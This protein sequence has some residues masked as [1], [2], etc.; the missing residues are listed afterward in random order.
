MAASELGEADAGLGTGGRDAD[1]GKYISGGERGLEQ[2]LEE[3]VGLDGAGA[4]R[5]GDGQFAI[6]RKHACRQFGGRISEGD[7]AA[8]RAAIADRGMTD[9]RHGQGDER[10]PPGELGRAFG[11]RVAHQRAD[12]QMSVA[13]HNPVESADAVEVDQQGGMAQSHIKRGDQ[14][15]SASEEARVVSAQQFD[16]MRDRASLGI[17]KRCRLQSSPPSGVFCI[18]AAGIGSSILAR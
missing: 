3:I 15:L 18:V 12:F 6:Q 13:R 2:A 7:R 16:R 14:A 4:L 8:D 17:G 5:P 1:S 10:S 9:M 11:L